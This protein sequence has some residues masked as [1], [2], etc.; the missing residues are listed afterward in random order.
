MTRQTAQALS[1]KSRKAIADAVAAAGGPPVLTIPDTAA[2]LGCSEMHIYRLIASGQLRAVD[3]ATPGAGLPKSRVR[4][5]D[6]MAYIERQT[7]TA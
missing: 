7:R 4:R 5:D 6:L 1:K 2:Q 3:I